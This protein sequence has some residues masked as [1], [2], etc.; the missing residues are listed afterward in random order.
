[1]ALLEKHLEDDQQVQVG[2]PENDLVHRHE[3]YYELDY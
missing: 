3:L 1:M 2:S